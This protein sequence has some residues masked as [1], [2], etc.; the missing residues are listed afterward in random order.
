[1][2]MDLKW[3]TGFFSSGVPHWT[4]PNLNYSSKEAIGTV[5]RVQ[6]WGTHSTVRAQEQLEMP[7]GEIR[8]NSQRPNISENEDLIPGGEK[9]GKTTIKVIAIQLCVPGIFFQMKDVV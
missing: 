2:S 4:I 5:H 7:S 3:A 8:H 6:L 9:K 1:M